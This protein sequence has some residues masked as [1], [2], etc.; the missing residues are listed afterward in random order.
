MCNARSAAECQTDNCTL[1]SA[2]DKRAAQA[3][4][5]LEQII[6]QRQAQLT[7]W[8]GVFADTPEELVEYTQLARDY[9][10]DATKLTL[11]MP[12]VEDMF[13]AAIEKAKTSAR[14]T[15]NTATPPDGVITVPGRRTQSLKV[16][17]G[18][19]GDLR[20]YRF[21]QGLLANALYGQRGW[22]QF[23]SAPALK[24]AHQYATEHGLIQQ[25]VDGAQTE[26]DPEGGGFTVR[27]EWSPD[28]IALY[29]EYGVI[30]KYA[31][32]EPMAAETKNI[33]VREGGLRFHPAG[34]LRDVEREKKKWSG[35]K[36]IAKKWLCEA[37]LSTELSED[38][39]VNQADDIAF[40]VGLAAIQL[41]DD[42]GFLADGSG[43]SETETGFQGVVGIIQKLLTVKLPTGAAA[44]PA[45]IAGL[46][47]AHGN[48]T[49]IDQVPLLLGDLRMATLLGDRSAMTIS[50][51]EH[52]SFFEDAIDLKGRI[53]NDFISHSPGNAD[54]TAAKR[55]AG[56]IVGLITD[57]WSDVTEDHINLLMGSLP[58]FRGI[59][60][61]FFCH[62][63]FYFQKLYKF[64]K[65]AG[66]TTPADKAGAGPFQYGGYPVEFCN[67]LP[68][69]AVA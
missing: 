65:A 8:A 2:A 50:M 46:V 68:P 27:E 48:P 64:L 34:E 10:R 40:E 53:R 66:G 13:K 44:T 35:R 54:A 67:N 20:A 31:K 56:A 22:D 69:V 47:V 9:G 37:K 3:P 4:P 55:K 39:S 38:S 12:A 45:Q 25:R 57:T 14:A 29:E 11:E 51:S 61:V 43:D 21:M 7:G 42:L 41:E 28:I 18:K 26:G 36:L 15:V 24:R 23:K 1:H 62:Q 52:S 63:T 60:P 32:V 6:A 49:K 30:R 33:L 19:D 58:R 17:K 5:T 59:K 16:F